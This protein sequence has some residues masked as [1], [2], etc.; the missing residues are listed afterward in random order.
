MNGL[1]G[2]GLK[3][4]LCNA[5]ISL[6]NIAWYL[7][8]LIVV[9]IIGIIGTIIWI[10]CAEWGY[11]EENIVKLWKGLLSLLKGGEQ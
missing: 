8:M 9:V 11:V 3:N 1:P 2:N 10:F 5:G 6:F 4:L 7:V